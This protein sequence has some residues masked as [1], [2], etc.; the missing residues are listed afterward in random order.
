VVSE[1]HS[2][3]FS[4]ARRYVLTAQYDQAIPEEDRFTTAT[5]SGKLVIL[6]DSPEASKMFAINKSFYLS[7][8][9]AP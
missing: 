1:V 6:V 9:P 2:F 4:I 7:L 5:P 3:P 8:T